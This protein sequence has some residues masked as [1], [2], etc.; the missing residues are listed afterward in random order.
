MR[1]DVVDFNPG[2]DAVLALYANG[3]LIMSGDYYHDKISERIEGFLEGIRFVKFKFTEFWH[4]LTEASAEKFGDNG[5]C[6]FP[7]RFPFKK[8]KLEEKTDD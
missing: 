5:W 7:N 6:D 1:I 8:Y 2:G 3:K 4:S